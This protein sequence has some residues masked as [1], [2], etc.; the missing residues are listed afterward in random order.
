MRALFTAATGMKAQQLKVDSIANNIANV[1]TNGFKKSSAE[2][3]DLY[4]SKVRSGTGT[5]QQGT[6]AANTVEVGH[7]ARASQVRRDFRG[8]SVTETGTPSHMAV[9]GNGFFAVTDPDGQELYTR[10]GNF[11]IDGNGTLVLPNGMALGDSITV[12]QGYEN[13]SIA[14]DGTVVAVVDGEQTP[15]GQIQLRT[16]TNPAG[17]DALGG[18]LYRDTVSSGTAQIGIPGAAGFG[19]IQGGSLEMSNVDVAEE[20][21][22]MIQAQ[23]AYELTGKVIEASDEMLQATNQLK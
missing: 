17:L 5:T 22:A 12:P 1:N 3:E 13:L 14:E 15:L 21:I 6:T 11:S 9:Q 7:G 8:G 16:F 10:T 20:L 4:Y 19:Q 2:F 18:G 23:R